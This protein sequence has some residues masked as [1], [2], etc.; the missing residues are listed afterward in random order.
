ML[1]K[2]ESW[3]L[4]Y[5]PRWVILKI[6]ISQEPLSTVLIHYWKGTLTEEFPCKWL[7]P[8]IDNVNDFCKCLL[9]PYTEK[10]ELVAKATS[11]SLTYDLYFQTFET[12]QWFFNGH[13]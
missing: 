9:G 12:F 10:Q 1:K 4:Y 2:Q 13:N 6:M 7:H 11:F 8:F 5:V 3:M